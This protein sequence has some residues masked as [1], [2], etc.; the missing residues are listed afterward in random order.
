MLHPSSLTI[1]QLF[2]Y[3]V[4][5][6]GGIEL[7]S[8]E[9]TDRGLKHDRRYMLIDEHNRFVS[10]R[11]LLIVSLL[12][13]FLVEDGFSIVVK[14]N[15]AASIML[16]LEILS[17]EEIKVE[18]WEDQCDAIRV[19]EKFDHWFSEQLNQHVR[20]VYMPHSSERIVDKDYARGRDLNSFSDGFPILLI[21]QTSLD[22]LN[23]RLKIPVGMDRFRPNLVFT[24]GMP[25]QEDAFH[26]FTCNELDFYAVKPCARC[27]MTTT[28]QD[29]GVTGSE[30]LHTL[31][32]YRKW[33]NK[34][35]FGQNVLIGS[36]GII[37]VGDEL[38]IIDNKKSNL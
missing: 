6:L 38:K 5:S 16:P 28:D 32:A 21:G 4:K 13:T 12:K 18:I 22:A 36:K 19:G 17:G 26:H 37:K 29:S 27:S 35:Y 34:I 31:A 33:K 7:K 9:I 25:H 15:A 10:Q 23:D 24:G 30:P 8:T 11:N 2:I 1:S 20:L 14:D 3:P